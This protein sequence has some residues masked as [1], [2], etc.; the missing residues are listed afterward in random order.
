M[1]GA[2]LTPRPGAVVG[3]APLGGW[4]LADTRALIGRTLRRSLR[5]PDTLL[6]GIALP[7][8]IMAMFVYVFGGAIDTGMAYVDYVVPGIVLLCAGYGASTTAVGVASDMTGGLM[9][10]FRSLPMRPAAALT[11]HVVESMVRNAVSTVLVVLVAYAA[12]FRPVA[13]PGAW[14]ATAALVGAYVLALTWIAVCMG[15]VASSPE[16]ASAFSFA[17]MFLPYVSS[18][19]VQPETMPRVLE[20]VARYQPVTPVTDTVR[21]WLTGA[22]EARPWVALAWCAGL[23]L[24]ARVGAVVLFRRRTR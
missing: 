7:V 18:A 3:R 19:F 13:G 21:A 1:T 10:R 17:I 16:A 15:I 8:I 11:G 6:M 5:T 23:F 20:L 9:N 4:A 22:G 2:T 12:G 24:A 14:L